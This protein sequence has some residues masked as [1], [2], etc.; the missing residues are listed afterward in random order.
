MWTH[1]YVVS[2]SY[3]DKWVHE[4]DAT[5]VK[6]W[7]IMIHIDQQGIYKDSRISYLSTEKYTLDEKRVYKYLVLGK[8]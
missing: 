4:E 8:T 6:E 7:F 3:S 2:G 1:I 5:C